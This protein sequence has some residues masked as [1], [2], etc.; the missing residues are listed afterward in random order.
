MEFNLS[1]WS[2]SNKYF[3]QLEKKTTKSNLDMPIKRLKSLFYRRAKLKPTV[4]VD[5]LQFIII[6]QTEKYILTDLFPFLQRDKCSTLTST[7][8]RDCV[9]HCHV[10]LPQTTQKSVLQSDMPKILLYFKL[11][12]LQ[13]TV[14]RSTVSIRGNGLLNDYLR[15]A[16]CLI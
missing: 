4:T 6:K 11:F 9:T 12:D 16:S 15:K 3:S 2:V 14:L 13:F 7:V 5:I 1:F 8:R 10:Q